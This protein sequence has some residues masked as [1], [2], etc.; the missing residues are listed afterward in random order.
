MTPLRQRM[1]EDMQLQGFSLGTQ[2]AYV[3]AVRQLADYYHRSPDGINEEEL[4]SYFLY[5]RSLI[6]LGQNVGVVI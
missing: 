5:F 1:I 3:R 4:R 2:Q 6:Y